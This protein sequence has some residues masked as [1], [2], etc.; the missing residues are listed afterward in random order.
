MRVS[1]TNPPKNALPSR[2][3]ARRSASEDAD[4]KR[5]A[6]STDYPPAQA[7]QLLRF[8][9]W[10]IP[11]VFSFALLESVAFAVF[12]EAGAGVT[13]A[14][15]LV[16]GLI[17]LLAWTRIRRQHEMQTTLV[18]ICSGF[19]VAA[20]VVAVAQSVLVPT[21]VLAPLLA[22]GI[23]LPYATERT[24]RLLFVTAWLVALTVSVLAETIPF[25]TALPRWYEASLR[26][27]SLAV[28]F[29]VVLVLLWLFRSQ[30]VGALKQA[31]RSEEWAVYDAKHDALTGLPN[32]ALLLERLGRALE[33][34]RKGEGY[35]FA[36][37]FLD[38]D[39]F[40]NLNDSL[41]HAVGDHLLIEV[42]RRLKA[43]VHPTDAVVRLGGDEFV[44]LLESITDAE[45]VK[46]VAE[47][48]HKELEG[49]FWLNEREIYSTA[50]IGIVAFPNGYREPEEL[51]RDADTAMYRAKEGGKAR[52]EIFN[53]EMRARA[54]SLLRLETDLRRAVERE[55]F[56][57]HYQPIVSLS[58][59]KIVGLEALLRWEHP[60]R[61]LIS[62]EEF[63]HLAEEM[64]LIVPIGTLVLREA[65][66][67]T[68][69]WRT[70]FPNLR[71][72]SVSVN[73]SAIQV[74]RP[75]LVDLVE[76]TLRKS[77]LDA[78]NLQ[79]ELTE[80]ALMREP[81]TAAAVLSDLRNLGVRIHI[82]DF[83]T[84][85]SSLSLL[86]RFTVDALKIDREF[87]G[88]M[89]VD[90]KD[91]EIVQ[92]VTTLAHSLGMY[93]VAEGVDAPERLRS[94][95][96]MSCEYGQGYLFS[97]PVDARTVEAIITSE[98]RW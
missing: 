17:L 57:V 48:V 65:C 90:G 22:V 40:K 53:A 1:K 23:A 30:L 55:E 37:L 98:R 51:L 26:I 94:L 10:L 50:S 29:A 86:H 83:G 2:Q 11:A 93:V 54:V 95:R 87:I 44:V 97:K 78:R 60:E 36:I 21:L 66:H 39:R 20:L 68:V 46:Q 19:L 61:G 24:L 64:G 7:A 73:L 74:A 34:T 85:Y 6:L 56:A 33:Q 58:S 82:D 8:L 43:C 80:G 72:L 9:A 81:G 32:R 96:K 77:G 14:T 13:A 69:R 5:A 70:A 63:V 91:A 35:Q 42:S 89:N 52:Y 76:G 59:G 18:I 84:G 16:Y 25:E 38:L 75:G 45:D 27:G 79:L 49:P 88:R 41:G 28:A 3:G 12:G 62:P 47:R 92:T 71:P 31:R 67:R 4:R 15:L